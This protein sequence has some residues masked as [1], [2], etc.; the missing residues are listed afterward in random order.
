MSDGRRESGGC[1]FLGVYHLGVAKC[2]VDLAP[3]IFDEFGFYGARLA[4]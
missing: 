1:G 2:I 4:P 3:H